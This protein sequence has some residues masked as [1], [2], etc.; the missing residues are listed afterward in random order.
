MDHIFLFKNYRAFLR[1]VIRRRFAKDNS[2]TQSH[3]ADE[4]GLKPNRFSEILSG[5]RGLSVANAGHVGSK[6]GL[7]KEEIDYFRDLVLA[8]HGR[9][10]S[11]K[12][13][14]KQRVD[15]R[16]RIV[17]SNPIEPG[18]FSTI[19]E[20]YHLAILEVFSLPRITSV[21][22]ALLSELF[23]IPR[24]KVDDAVER[25]IS[26]GILTES[27][28]CLK[29]SGRDHDVSST[30]PSSHIQ[31]FH[32]QILTRANAAL[33]TQDLSRREFSTS[34]FA[35]ESSKM[36]FAKARVANFWKDFYAE[37]GSSSNPD[38]IYCLQLA[39]FDLTEKQ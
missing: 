18:K 26:I 34:I 20:W 28:G 17:N 27:N 33:L 7:S 39:F 5:K 22:R 37:F 29:I 31:Q 8:E 1:E 30:I 24:R 21:T 14:A 32:S 10:K 6:L 16:Q 4:L 9:T 3:I 38:R 2:I 15:L 13:E 23:N 35:F 12:S 36:P 11:A 19:S 25:L